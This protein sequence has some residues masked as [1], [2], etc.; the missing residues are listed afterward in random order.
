MFVQAQSVLEKS[1]EKVSVNRIR[2]VCSC[3]YVCVHESSLYLDNV[4]VHGHTYTNGEIKSTLFSS[5]V[6][7]PTGPGSG[8]VLVVVQVV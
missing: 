8:S 3:V 1:G 7:P 2:K 5:L 4:C 6:I